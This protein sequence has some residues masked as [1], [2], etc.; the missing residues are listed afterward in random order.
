MKQMITLCADEVDYESF[1]SQCLNPSAA[2]VTLQLGAWA[3]M[4]A[5]MSIASKSSSIVLNA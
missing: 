4:D 5:I 1:Q 3:R 2:Q